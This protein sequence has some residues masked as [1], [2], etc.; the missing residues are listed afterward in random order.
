MPRAS[1]A[2]FLD[3]LLRHGT[4]TA[5]AYC[6]VAP[7][8]GRRLLR[9]GRGA[10]HADDRRQGDDGPQLPR[11]ACATR[12]SPAYDDT[13]A[14]IDRWH[15]KGR[16]LYAITPRF[17]ITS[18]PEQMEMAQALVARA[19]RPAHADASVGEPRRDRLHPVALPGG[20]RL[21]RRL[22]ALRPARAEE[23][24]RPRDPPLRP[25]DRGD[26]RDRLGR[27]LLPDLEPLPRLA[28]STTRSACARR[29]SAARSPP[30]S[31][32]APTIRCC[33]PSTRATRCSRCAARSSTRSSAFWW[34]TR[35]NAEALSLGGPD[36]HARAGHRG[37]HRRARQ[38]APRRRWR[39]GARR[40]RS[41]AEELFL[42]QT[43]GRRP[44]G[45]RDLCRRR[46]LGARRRRGR[47][48]QRSRRYPHAPRVHIVCT[49]RVHDFCRVGLLGRAFRGGAPSS[50][51]MKPPLG[52]RLAVG[53]LCG[54]PPAEAGFARW[55]E[56]FSPAVAG[57]PATAR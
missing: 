6:S 23:P 1:P 52:R 32:A 46:A 4:T 17:A 40:I 39:S 9:R 3:E 24:V 45:G 7:G 10:Q 31:A 25:R 2:L 48:G 27:G 20:A 18:T 49:K 30:M 44:G 35:G 36:R 21:P 13:K 11:R 53:R 33:A 22:R 29:A 34:I 43:L 41:L 19:S 5:V 56:I 57:A 15:G 50:G 26:G 14:L 16:A 47:K 38:R 55:V 42:L 12:R 8:L 28:A 54:L 37:R 51:G